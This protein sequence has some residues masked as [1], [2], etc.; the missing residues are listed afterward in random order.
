M[1]V[2]TGGLYVYLA[3]GANM[4]SIAIIIVIVQEKEIVAEIT[5]SKDFLGISMP[6]FGITKEQA[7]QT[8][9]SYDKA[10]RLERVKSLRVYLFLKYFEEHR[11]P[12]G[13][14]VV[15]I[16]SDTLEVSFA[17]KAYPSLA[18]NF[19]QL[20]PIDLLDRLHERFGPPEHIIDRDFVRSNLL[21]VL[22]SNYETWINS[23]GHLSDFEIEVEKIKEYADEHILPATEEKTFRE[24]VFTTV[25]E[26]CF[27]CRQHSEALGRLSEEQIRD[28]YLVI[29]KCI[30]NYAGGETFHYDG[31]LDFQIINPKNKYEMI[32]G[33][34]KWWKSKLSAAEV[35][36]QAVRKHA[37]GQEAEIYA[38]L[39]NKNINAKAVFEHAKAYFE[40]EPE[41]IVGSYKDRTPVGSRESFGQFQVIIRGNQIPLCL[42]VSDFYHKKI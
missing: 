26:F 41:T 33:E 5:F 2:F 42:G 12:Y 6:M 1:G 7:I 36:K 40:K 15:V 13:L 34:F 14:L 35:F 29:V 10:E 28:L 17:M 11:E 24:R 23:H 25:H 16:D 19:F 18:H 21:F 37:T 22:S 20:S 38:L 32:T 8:I 39:L 4:S 30:F 27:Y 9:Q 31:K 3:L